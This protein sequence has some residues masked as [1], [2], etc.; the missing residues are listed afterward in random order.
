MMSLI[1]E[2]ETTNSSGIIMERGPPGWYI[3]GRNSKMT[4]SRK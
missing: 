3:A 4:R 1:I 2:M